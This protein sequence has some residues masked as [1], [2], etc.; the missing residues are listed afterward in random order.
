[1]TYTTPP[2]I[3][4]YWYLGTPYSLYPWGLTRAFEDACRAAGWF[5][6][7]RVPYYCPIAETHPI[8][9]VAG[10]DPKEHELW[11]A[12]DRPKLEAAGGLMVVTMP[13]FSRSRGIALEIEEFL[14]TGRPIWLMHWRSRRFS[15]LLQSPL[16]EEDVR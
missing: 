7:N 1:M 12:A 6:K 5:V 16:R 4:G 13:T 8:A 3:D 14:P 2:P 15:P 11:M 9:V 10:I